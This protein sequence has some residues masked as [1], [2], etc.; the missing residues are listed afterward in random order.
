MVGRLER[1]ERMSSQGSPTFQGSFPN[2]KTGVQ[3][4]KSKA[5]AEAL[6]GHIPAIQSHP[7]SCPKKF[8][9]K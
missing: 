9:S 7:K 3:T 8:C 5:G 6:P 1:A 2:M 4:P